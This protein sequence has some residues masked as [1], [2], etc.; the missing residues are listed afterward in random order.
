MNLKHIL[1]FLTLLSYN[2]YA[3]IVVKGKVTNWMNAPLLGSIQIEENNY[4]TTS[5][6]LGNF[7]VQ[8][9]EFGNYNLQFT[10]DKTVHSFEINIYDSLDYIIIK[11]PNHDEENQLDELVIHS[12]QNENYRDK[13]LISKET[14][15]PT[16]FKKTAQ[17]NVFES[18]SMVNGVKPKVNCGVCST[19]D[20]HINGL[21]GP[22]TFVL[23]DGMPLVSGLSTVYGLSGIPNQL[24]EKVEVIKGPASSVYG[25]EAIGGMINIITKNPKLASKWSADSFTTSWGEVNTDVGLSSPL[26]KNAHW[27]LGVNYFNYSNPIDNNKDGFTDLT[28][29]DRISLFQKIEFYRIS[30]KQFSIATRYYYEDRWGGQMNW[31]NNH[32]GSDQVYGESIYTNRW[33]LLGL[34]EL[35]TIENIKIQTSLIGH[36]QNSMYGTTSYKA[37][38]N[39][40]FGQMIWHKNIKNHQLTSG[41]AHKYQY[42]NDNTVAT[43]TAENTHLSSL[44]IQDEWQISSKWSTLLGARLDYHSVHKWIP[45]PR[46][47]LKY[48]SDKGDI[49][50]INTGT[51]FRVV[52]IFTEDHAALSGSREIIIDGNLK[53]EKSLNTNLSYLKQWFSKNHIMYQLETSVW[54]TYFS[55]AILPNYDI[56]PNKIFYSNLNG[57]SISKGVNIN[58][59]IMLPNDIKAV[60]GT[61]IQEVFKNENGEKEIQKFTEKYSANWALTLPIK[62]ADLSVDYVGNLTGPMQLPLLSNTDPRRSESPVF[63]IHNIQL[64]YKGFK[65]LEIYTGV[66]NI[67]DWTINKKNPFVISRAHDPFD[68]NVEYTPNGDVLKT[69]E[70]PYGLM[71]DPTYVYGP[72]QGRRTYIGLRISI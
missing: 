62:K 20:I 8:I 57:N 18:L 72:F 50:R 1:I 36:D 48:E 66:K 9:E 13:G 60:I 56:D 24:I 65:W 32:R 28:I 14:Y 7:L 40:F 27:L 46:F 16:F 68:K 49:I 11:T 23:I 38:Q 53:P 51:G 41:I 70:N 39:I 54:Y 69:T 3:Q 17:S 35:P 52:S 33:E 59:D 5:D 37:K 15:T 44:Y 42:Y 26:G 30:K 29:Q 4:S 6:S 25:S 45:T 12:Y 64:T 22:Y 10:E 71:F 47:A 31:N 67:T 19:G 55:N 61:T 2:S 63:S 43:T 21:E 58:L 34:Y